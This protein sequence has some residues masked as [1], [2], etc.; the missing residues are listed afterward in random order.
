MT[1]VS[2]TFF[3]L[4]GQFAV[5]LQFGHIVD[6]AIQLPLRVDLGL[7]TQSE[8]A[9]A[10]LLDVAEHRLDQAHAVGIDRTAFGAVDFP[11]HGAAM[12]VG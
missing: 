8:A 5:D 2:R 4:R 11:A 6:D 9:Q 3:G 1:R 10:A 12:G 7:T